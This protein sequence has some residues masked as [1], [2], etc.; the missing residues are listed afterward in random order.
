M[1]DKRR[2]GL[3]LLWIL[4]FSLPALAK[5]PRLFIGISGGYGNY[6]DAFQNTGT[7]GIIRFSFGSLLPINSSFVIGNQIAFQTGSQI[8]LSNAITT[9][10][11]NAIVPVFISTKTPID[12]LLIGRYNFQEPLFFELKGGVAVFSSTISGAD[13]QTKDSWLPEVPVGMG[14]NVYKRSRVT[15]GYQQFFGSTPIITPLDI[16]AGTYFLKGIPMWRGALLT[17]EHDM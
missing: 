3:F 17:F 8:R 2:K 5:V 9:S 13:I 14:F 16:T 1:D 7:T 11:G 10:M 12:F 15:L 4:C 6:A